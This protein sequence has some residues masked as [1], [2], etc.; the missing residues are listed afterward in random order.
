[1]WAHEADLDDIVQAYIEPVCTIRDLVAAFHRV[2]GLYTFDTFCGLN[3][4]AM[5]P[6]HDRANLWTC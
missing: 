3:G 1:M 4:T 5:T 6:H 2:H